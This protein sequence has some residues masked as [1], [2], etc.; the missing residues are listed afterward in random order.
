[1]G[2]FSSYSL[3]ADNRVTMRL[4]WTLITNMASPINMIQPATRISQ[5]IDH[6]TDLIGRC[7]SWLTVVMVAT[8]IAVVITRYFL[9]IGSIALQESVTYLHAAVFLLGIGYTLKHD[10]HVRVDIFYRQ[11]SVKCKAAVDL[12]GT[13]L[14]L[15]PISSLI[16]YASWDYVMASWATGETSAENNGL[17]FIYILK[18]LM[19]LMPATLLLQGIAEALKNVLRLSGHV[20]NEEAEAGNSLPDNHEPIL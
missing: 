16:Y 12:V 10:G 4:G 13:V 18:T 14:F 2:F 3:A 15:L 8:V 17:P 6:V 11:F 7:V 5:S 9:Q 20:N 19:L 1:M